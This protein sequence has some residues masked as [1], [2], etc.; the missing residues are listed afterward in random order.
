MTKFNK[1]HF[2]LNLSDSQT[3]V[4]P[5][6]GTDPD[7]RWTHDDGRPV[8]HTGALVHWIIKTFRPLLLLLV[9]VDVVVLVD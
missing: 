2:S 5:S 1:T 6:R 3:T 4:G 7:L 8:V 9:V